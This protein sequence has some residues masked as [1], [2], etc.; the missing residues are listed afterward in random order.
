MDL[1][2]ENTS[3]FT[4]RAF[5]TGSIFCFFVAIMCQ[6]SVN[7]VHGSYLAIDHMPAGGIFIFFVFTL[8]IN[9]ILR[10]LGIGFSSSEQLLIYTM[11]I[12]CS[13]VVTMGFGSQILPML[14]APFY[15]ATA[16]N[17]WAQLIQMIE[18]SF[19]WPGVVAPF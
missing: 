19:F 2:K 6:Y 18:S 7:I 14:A 5:I 9:T 3:G 8:L 12:V 16:E 11:L 13:S 15:Y 10:K 4:L 17:R 1:V